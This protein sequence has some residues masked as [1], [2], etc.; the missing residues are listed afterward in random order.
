MTTNTTFMIGIRDAAISLD[1]PQTE[2]R[3]L[4]R[5]GELPGFSGQQGG[6]VIPFPAIEK[7]MSGVQRARIVYDEDGHPLG[8]GGEA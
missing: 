7:R 1:V 3:R 4:V 2:I 8:I 6:T 5:V